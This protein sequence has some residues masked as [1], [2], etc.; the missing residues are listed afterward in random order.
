VVIP[1]YSENCLRVDPFPESLK[2]AHPE[3]MPR[4]PNCRETVITAMTIPPFPKSEIWNSDCGM[5]MKHQFPSTKSQ[6]IP[7]DRNQKPKQS[8]GGEP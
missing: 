4:L 2:E 1:S 8:S 5:K 3:F 6:I 7:K